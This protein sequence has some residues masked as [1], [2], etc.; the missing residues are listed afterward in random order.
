MMEEEARESVERL[1]MSSEFRIFLLSVVGGVN[2]R[3]G[4]SWRMR[5]IWSSNLSWAR[6]TAGSTQSDKPKRNVVCCERVDIGAVG[7]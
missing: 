1:V 2:C 4:S 3:A 7:L 5:F 6:S